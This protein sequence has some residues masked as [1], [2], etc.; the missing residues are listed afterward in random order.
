MGEY[1][2][3]TYWAISESLEHTIDEWGSEVDFGEIDF[4]VVARNGNYSMYH[5]KMW[6][7]GS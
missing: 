4:K 3:E 7:D 1:Y 6:S 5:C 2:G